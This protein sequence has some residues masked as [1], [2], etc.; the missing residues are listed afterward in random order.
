MTGIYPTDRDV[1]V[2]RDRDV[3]ARARAQDTAP[4]RDD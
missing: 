2:D 4:G 3:D 1:D